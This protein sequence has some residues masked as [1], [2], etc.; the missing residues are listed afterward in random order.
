VRLN[1]VEADGRV[2]AWRVRVGG[3]FQCRDATFDSN[4]GGSL[5]LQNAEI[6]Q[7]G[8]FSGC[9]AQG[10]MDLREATFGR[11]V[12][13]ARAMIKGD[14]RL[15]RCRVDD[16][17]IL[18][19]IKLRAWRPASDD[20]Y[21]RNAKPTFGSL[22]LRG[23]RLGRLQMIGPAI[24]NS[25]FDATGATIDGDCQFTHVWF[26][27][28]THVWFGA[29]GGNNLN[30]S[31]VR[32]AGSL[33]VEHLRSGRCNHFKTFVQGLSAARLNDGPDSWPEGAHDTH[34]VDNISV[35]SVGAPHKSWRIEW[36]KKN[37]LL[38][39]Q[40]WQELAAALQRGGYEVE[41]RDLAIA[42]EDERTTWTRAN[43]RINIWPGIL[44]STIG[45]GYKP[46]RAVWWAM[47]I[48]G[49]CTVLFA[50]FGHF[51]P[52]D[53]APGSPKIF[54]S[55]DAFLPVDLGYFGAWTP[56]TWISAV[57]AVEVALGWLLAALLVGALTGL[58]KKD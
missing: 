22:G 9:T 55:A 23:A 57:A 14:L 50:L 45:Y 40:P 49:V 26:G 32:I 2:S 11:G 38:S 36:L 34:Y 46:I 1:H 27:A 10:V 41:A 21:K 30:L 13:F 24:V 3:A 37:Q 16:D 52:S 42:R 29:I 56:Q 8:D 33:T 12:S 54:Y 25:N 19:Q 35:A 6:G 4:Q 53:G 20:E 51:E 31:N 43:R 39:P 48:V 5:N 18:D 15:E 44:K 28:I 47:G 17:L 58:L 7:V